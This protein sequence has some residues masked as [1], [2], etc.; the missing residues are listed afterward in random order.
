MPT[1]VLAEHDNKALNE[2]SARA[3]TAA[4]QLGEPVHVLVAGHHCAA[5]ADAAARLQGVDTVVTADDPL[6]AHALAEPMAA[7]IVT[8][9]SRYNAI[10]APASANG[11]N[12]LP[13]AAALLDVQQISEVTA[14]LAPRRFE[15]MIYAGSLIETVEAPPGLLVLTLRTTGFAPAQTGGAALIIGVP[16]GP[17]PGLSCFTGE[18]LSEGPD[19]GSAK[20]VVAGGRGLQSAE[21]FQRLTKIAA[22][23]GAAIGATRAAVDQGFISNDH[24]IG[25]SGKIVAPD[26]YIAIG[27]S[28]A[29]QHLAGIKDAKIIAAIN[30]DGEAPIFQSADVGLVA[31][32]FQ[33][34]PELEAELSKRLNGTKS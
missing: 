10:L 1:L 15:R 8:L 24:Q 9:A 4:L 23:L 32:L 11:K 6:Y 17:D 12:I 7:L 14:I 13:R 3:V 21:N 2:A 20:T 5:A 27:L 18:T 16:A 31:D 26:L 25:Q 33:A 28:G 34:L 19:L 30:K 22:K 29:I